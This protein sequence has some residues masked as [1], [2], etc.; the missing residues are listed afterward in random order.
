MFGIILLSAGTILHLYVF[1]RAWPVPLLQRTLGRKGMAGLG[2]F[3][4]LLLVAGRAFGHGATG[5]LGMVI[6]VCGMT[7]LGTLFLTALSL[8]AA[9]LITGFGVVLPK[10]S[11][12]VR[13]GALALG[14]LLSLIALIQGNRAPVI[15]SYEVDLRGLPP[16]LDGT[17]IV[18]VS[19]LHLGTVRGERWLQERIAQVRE[20]SPDI[21]VLLGDIFEGHGTPSGKPG[22]VLATLRAPRG[23]WAVLGNHEFHGR[24]NGISA[25]FREAGI[26]LLR[27]EQVEVLPG[28]ALAGVD[29]LTSNRRTG[30]K[31]DLITRTFAGSNGDATVLLSHTP[32]GAEQAANAG[33]GLML[34]GHTHGG[35]IWPFGYIVKRFYPLLA[36]RYAVDG[37]TVI[38]SRGAGLWGPPMRLW[39]PG[40]IIKVTLRAKKKEA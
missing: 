40:E 30:G 18:G 17:V 4:W 16:A 24:D 36:G 6:E 8:L 31:A 15:T 1:W 38:V 29:D 25:L 22:S 14:A 5:N 27:N 20:A 13:S 32:W 37:M 35:Q 12:R 3:L 9:D 7:W 19:D 33:A 28:L 26:R 10:I 39:K 2:V 11:L 23:V 21:I 34:C